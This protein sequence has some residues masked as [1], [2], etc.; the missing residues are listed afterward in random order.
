MAYIFVDVAVQLELRICL[1]N[2][3]LGSNYGADAGESRINILK[4]RRRSEQHVIDTLNPPR[5]RVRGYLRNPKTL[6]N[7]YLENIDPDA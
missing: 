2:N 4:N 1:Y 3:T 7:P 6:A 5:P